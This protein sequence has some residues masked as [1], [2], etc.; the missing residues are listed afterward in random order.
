MSPVD[1]IFI[2]WFSVS[3]INRYIEMAT[4]HLGA[5]AYFIELG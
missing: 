2:S 3:A 4:H 5:V 1:V